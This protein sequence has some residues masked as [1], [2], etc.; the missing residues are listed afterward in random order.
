MATITLHYG[1]LTAA[2]ARAA[3]FAVLITVIYVGCPA[4]PSSRL[5]HMTLYLGIETKD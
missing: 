2:G 4:F 3:F 5:G 1:L